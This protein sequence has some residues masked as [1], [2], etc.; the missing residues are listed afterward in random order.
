MTDEDWWDQ[1]TRFETHWRRT[2]TQRI[3][4]AIRDE[5]RTYGQLSLDVIHGMRLAIDAINNTPKDT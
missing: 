3:Q 5:E 4:Q 1:A 2:H